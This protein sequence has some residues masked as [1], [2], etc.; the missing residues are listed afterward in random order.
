V[1]DVEPVFRWQN[2]I[3]IFSL[4]EWNIGIWTGLIW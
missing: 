2:T 1:K 4:N 3:K